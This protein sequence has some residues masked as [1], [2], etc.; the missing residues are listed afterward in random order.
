M[1]ANEL[2]KNTN[3]NFLKH[4][5]YNLLRLCV[6]W[7]QLNY[8]KKINEEKTLVTFSFI[9][10]VHVLILAEIKKVIRER[11]TPSLSSMI[12]LADLQLLSF[13]KINIFIW[14]RE[15]SQTDII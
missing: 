13:T 8:E 11:L 12:S 14:K 2:T 6:S 10:N 9:A 1:N 3:N 5:Q 7:K 15:V 4:Y